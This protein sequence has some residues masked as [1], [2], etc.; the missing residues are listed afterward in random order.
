MSM[1][2]RI[3]EEPTDSSSG[4]SASIPHYSGHTEISHRYA[5]VLFHEYIT[6]FQVSK[7]K[8]I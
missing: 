2:K 6:G 8:T 3:A 7:H 4:S 1:N 5:Q